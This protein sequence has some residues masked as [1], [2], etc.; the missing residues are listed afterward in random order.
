MGKD[1]DEEEIAEK[2]ADE[3]D[4]RIKEAMGKGELFKNGNLDDIFG[5]EA[6]DT[7]SLKSI[8]KKRRSRKWRRTVRKIRDNHSDDVDLLQRLVSSAWIKDVKNPPNLDGLFGGKACFRKWADKNQL[9]VRKK[10]DK[11]FNSESMWNE[12]PIDE[13]TR[14]LCEI[15]V[16]RY[17]VVKKKPQPGVSVC[18]SYHWAA[19]A[20]WTQCDIH[21]GEEGKRKRFR[22]CINS[23]TGEK[24]D[25]KECKPFNDPRYDKPLTNEDWTRCSPC[26]ETEIASWTEWSKWEVVGSYKMFCGE[27][28]KIKM[29]RRRE[30]LA[31][32]KGQKKC[33]GSDKLTRDADAPPCQ[34]EGSG[35][36]DNMS[37]GAEKQEEGGSMVGGTSEEVKEDVE[38]TVSSR[39][40][41]QE[42]Q[43]DHPSKEEEGKE[44]VVEEE[45]KEEEGEIV[46]E[47]REGEEGEIV[48]EGRE[49]EEGGEDVLVDRGNDG[50]GAAE[51][52]EDG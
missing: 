15:K 40:G 30:C 10:G 19:W 45:G 32:E 26:P 42:K 31:G 12:E 34:G 21:C 25:D 17:T 44:G 9:T 20:E 51:G 11:K 43:E 41:N 49:G 3:I 23:C 4:G 1:K 6:R 46:E 35:Y 2:F 47:G 5:F 16:C 36:V 37:G 50:E 14:A 8:M 52:G 18:K 27:N 24:S 22:K 29:Q 28:V 39:S 7:S 48:E 38:E 13:C 33:E